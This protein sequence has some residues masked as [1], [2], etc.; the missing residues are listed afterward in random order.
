MLPAGILNQQQ[1]AKMGTIT[2]KIIMEAFMRRLSLA[3]M[4]V[5]ILLAAVITGC[6]SGPSFKESSADS[7]SAI[8]AAEEVGA[9]KLPSAALYLQRAKEELAQAEMLAAKG[10]KEQ[11]ASLLTRAE[12]DAE[13]A[14]TLSKEQG[15]KAEAAKAMARVRQLRDENQLPTE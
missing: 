6:A 4:V 14:I 3:G 5:V 7:K 9:D 12:A 11:A 1:M 13:L 8:R 2:R 15:E 10:Q